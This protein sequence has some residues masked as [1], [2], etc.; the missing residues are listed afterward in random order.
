[1]S[2]LWNK[3]VLKPRVSP[4]FVITYFYNHCNISSTSQG[5]TWKNLDTVTIFQNL[6]E[7]S[8]TPRWPLS[9]LL[10]RSYVWLY[11]RIILSKSH[12][13]MSKVCGYSDPFFKT[14]NQRS[15]TPRWPLTPSLLRSHVC[16]YPRI[17]ASKSH[18]NTVCGYSDPFFKNFNQRW[19]IDDLWPHICWSHMCDSTQ[20]SLCPSP[21]GIH[22]CMW[23]QWSILQNTTY[24][25]R[26][27]ILCTEWVIT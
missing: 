8:M 6:T 23:I 7:R 16:L 11:P 20:E 10:L 15:L 1:M 13:N 5:N 2:I 9:P 3:A 4:A 14:L 24:I 22:Q 21:M 26:T 27:Y 25:L 18:E 19:P 17:I 12:E